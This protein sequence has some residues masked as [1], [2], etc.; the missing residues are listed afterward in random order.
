MASP[1][2]PQ[3][4]ARALI[5]F[6]NVENYNAA[7]RTAVSTWVDDN[8][9]PLVS[10][11]NPAALVSFSITSVLQNESLQPPNYGDSVDPVFNDKMNLYC[12]YAVNLVIAA[13]AAGG[14]S[15]YYASIISQSGVLAPTIESLNYTN[16]PI[17]GTWGYDSGGTYIITFAAS[18][19]FA[20]ASKVEVWVGALGAGVAANWNAQILDANKI[21]LKTYLLTQG[22]GVTIDA[23][24]T[25]GLLVGTPFKI[26]VYP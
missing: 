3:L 26:L 19:Y 15:L 18:G 24:P 25:D 21:S 13:N 5:V 10:S 23:T 14:V 6:P 22:A 1:Y 11:S 20:S 7:F 8:I 4:Q 17:S 16:M 12:Q 2:L 9:I